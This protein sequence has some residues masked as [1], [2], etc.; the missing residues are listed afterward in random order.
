MKN[1]VKRFLLKIK[2]G[3]LNVK[4]AK[5]SQIAVSSFFGGCNRIG[6]NSR[7]SGSL[8]Y[9]SYIG[10]DCVINAKIGKYCSIASGVRTVRGNHP[11]KDWVSTHPAFFSPNMQCGMTYSKEQRFEEFKAPIEIGNDVWIGDSVLLMDGVEIGDGAIIAA[12][13]VVA[14]NVPPYAVVGGVP[15]KTIRYRFDEDQINFLLNLKW[16][17]KDEKW[18]KE[19]A[20]KFSDVRNLM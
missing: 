3:K 18:I 14:K 11:S 20:E 5:N 12:G 19:N 17:E 9:A 4:F 1:A 7:F 6:K 13:A 8:G 15:A 2:Y 16:W 10:E